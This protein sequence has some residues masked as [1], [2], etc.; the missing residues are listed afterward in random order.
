MLKVLII[1]HGVLMNMTIPQERTQ[2][3]SWVLETK[4]N[5][6]VQ[7]NY[8]LK[9]Q[10]TPSPILE[11]WFSTRSLLKKEMPYRNWLCVYVQPYGSV[12]MCLKFKL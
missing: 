12:M 10:K 9:K 11:F 4:S 5:T 8:N 6:E 3:L 2:C 7:Q 1:G